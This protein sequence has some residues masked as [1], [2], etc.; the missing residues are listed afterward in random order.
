MPDYQEMYLT[1]A[2]ESGKAIRLLAA[3]QQACEKLYPGAAEPEPFPPEKPIKK[4]A[5]APR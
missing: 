4:R 3:A 5:D 1:M 2:R